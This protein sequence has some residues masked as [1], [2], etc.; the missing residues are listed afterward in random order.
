MTLLL[1]AAPAVAFLILSWRLDRQA[2][3]RRVETQL[4]RLG[5]VGL[6]DGCRA[7]KAAQAAARRAADGCLWCAEMCGEAGPHMTATYV[8]GLDFD[9]GGDL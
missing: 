9:F 4:S 2:R 8:T 6:R 7:A 1:L 3:R 5:P